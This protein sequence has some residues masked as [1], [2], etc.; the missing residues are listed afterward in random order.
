MLTVYVMPTPDIDITFALAPTRLN[1][2]T[3]AH[4]TETDQ[5]LRDRLRR[6]IPG[7]DTRAV[8]E[9]QALSAAY[10]RAATRMPI[11]PARQSRSYDPIEIEFTLILILDGPD[12]LPRDQCP[13]IWAHL[14]AE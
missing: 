14:E 13:T 10:R 8:A 6:E 9:V 5:D 7:L 3:Y 2:Y 12:P 11:S 1:T 4:P